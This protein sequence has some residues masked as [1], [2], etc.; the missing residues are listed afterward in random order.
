MHKLLIS[1]ILAAVALNLFLP[2]VLKMVATRKQLSP[3]DSMEK[4]NLW[5]KVMHMLVHHN[6]SPVASSIVVAIVVA[7][8]VF[9]GHVIAK[10]L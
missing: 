5:D 10:K 1:T 8:S 4:M 6:N 3:S 9:L 2:F 7:A